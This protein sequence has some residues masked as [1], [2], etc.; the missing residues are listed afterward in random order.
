MD[1]VAHLLVG[2]GRWTGGRENFDVALR[3]E[4][5][6]LARRKPVARLYALESC[7]GVAAPEPLGEADKSK[8]RALFIAWGPRRTLPRTL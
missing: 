2:A 5:A 4:L 3:K 6:L 8:K 7:Q 1:P